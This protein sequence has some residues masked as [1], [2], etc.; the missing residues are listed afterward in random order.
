MAFSFSATNP[1]TG[2][3]NS[4]VVVSDS[5]A[6]HF[7]TDDITVEAWIKMPPLWPGAN[8]PTFIGKVARSSPYGGIV[9]D[10][11]NLSGK[12]EFAVTVC[13]TVSCGWRTESKQPVV[14][15]SRI[16]DDR[17]H[18]VADVRISTGY[19]LYVDG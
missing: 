9:F 18:H 5:P 10:I 8:L 4:V 11:D 6:L 17:W 16:D 2:P 14:S 1:L 7:G 13:G 19:R 12:L 15:A 3:S